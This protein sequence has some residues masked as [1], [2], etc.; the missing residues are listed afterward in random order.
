MYIKVIN[1]SKKHNTYQLYGNYT[2]PDINKLRKVASFWTF[3]GIL[4]ILFIKIVFDYDSYLQYRIKP[5]GD[6]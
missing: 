6:V 5:V 4:L 3:I 1:L 2:T